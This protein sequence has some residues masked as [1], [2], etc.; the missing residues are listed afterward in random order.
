M[1]WMK[2]EVDEKDCRLIS[3]EVEIQE[4]YVGVGS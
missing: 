2:A 1:A 3:S 4:A